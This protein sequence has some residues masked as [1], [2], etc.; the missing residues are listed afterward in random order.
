[1][2]RDFRLFRDAGPVILQMD[3]RAAW[4]LDAGQFRAL[5]L[6]L[7][8]LAMGLLLLTWGRVRVLANGYQIME[9]R[10][11]RDSLES[12]H[13]ALQSRLE[14]MQSLAWAEQAAR[15]QLHMV[16]IN[17]NQ[18]ITLRTRGLGSSLVDSVESLFHR[19]QPE[20]TK[21]AP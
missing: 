8:A 1:M 14:Q 5:V 11:E 4:R 13:R 12:Q 3:R 7:V 21:A 17:P 20:A 2:A 16:D 15:E 10:Q 9:L 19:G 6:A 18:V